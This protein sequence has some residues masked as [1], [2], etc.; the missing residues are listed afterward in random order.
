MRRRQERTGTR[1]STTRDPYTHQDEYTRYSYQEDATHRRSR[2]SLFSLS[3]ATKQK[4]FLVI[5]VVALLV[6]W[7]LTPVSDWIVAVVLWTVPLEADI[8]L[9]RESYRSLKRQYKPVKDRWNVQ[10]IGWDLVSKSLVG[11]NN[12]PEWEW[13]FGV[14]DAPFINAFALPGGIIRVTST[15]LKELDLTNAELAA[16]LG[17]EMGH[18]LHRH[19][20]AKIIKSKLFTMILKAVLYEDHDDDEETFGEA[21][22]ELLLQSAKYLGELKFSR[23]NEYEADA[24]A[25]DLLKTSQAYSPQALESLLVKLEG[26]TGNDS[27]RKMSWDST[28]PGTHERIQAL[29]EKWTRLDPQEQ[30]WKLN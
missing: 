12:E 26:A 22:G 16:L 13:N 15:L 29:H 4:I 8:E 21:V 3:P 7:F 20:Q 27:R 25:W 18:V 28:H 6:I 30:R 9:G 24:A 1:G 23:K 11:E 5:G 10:R 2:Q 17:H 14:V 19:S